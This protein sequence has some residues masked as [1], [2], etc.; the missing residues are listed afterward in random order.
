MSDKET[1]SVSV[2]AAALHL[3]ELYAQT[4]SGS[5]GGA[6]RETFAETT[7]S[8]LCLKPNSK[9][10]KLPAS[11]RSKVATTASAISDACMLDQ[12]RAP[13]MRRHQPT[14]SETA[15]KSLAPRLE[16]PDRYSR[17]RDK[18]KS[19]EQV[20]IDR[21]RREYKRE[22]KAISRELRLDAAFIENERRQEDAAKTNRARAER[23]KNFSWL[24]TEQAAM[25][26]QVRQGG[27]LLK[28]GGMGAAKNKAKTAKLG[29]KKG[30]K[31]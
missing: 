5:L 4:L 2:L 13:L 28:G 7:N 8:L 20:A 18:G 19:S 25:N 9:T 27:G 3:S 22:H 26:Q 29:M 15:T 23:Q 17:S 1:T 6:E 16:D 30:G 10:E 11:I 12:E 31:L 21:T 14:K 24:E